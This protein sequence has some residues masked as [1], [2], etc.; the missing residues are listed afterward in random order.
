[1]VTSAAAFEGSGIG[2]LLGYTHHCDA[3]QGFQGGQ[4]EDNVGAIAVQLLCQRVPIQAQND[5]VNQSLFT[6]K[7]K[8]KKPKNAS[9]WFL[10]LKMPNE[11][12]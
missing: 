5:E 4:V 10:F 12:E 11:F 7:R 2:C 6:K 1:M 9:I 8:K 3:I